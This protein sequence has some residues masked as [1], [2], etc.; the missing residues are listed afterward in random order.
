MSKK[1]INK[2]VVQLIGLVAILAIFCIISIFQSGGNAQT[3]RYTIKNIDKLIKSTNLEELPYQLPDRPDKTVIN[4]QV[5]TEIDIDR[6]YQQDQVYL[7]YD[8]QGVLKTIRI[9][10]VVPGINE[11]GRETFEPVNDVIYTYTRGEDGKLVRYSEINPMQGESYVTEVTYDGNTVKHQKYSGIDLVAEF[12]QEFDDLQKMPKDFVAYNFLQDIIQM[13]LQNKQCKLVKESGT[14]EGAVVTYKYNGNNIEI[15]EDYSGEKVDRLVE[16]Q[17]N[18]VKQFNDINN[19]DIYNQL[20][21]KYEGSQLNQITGSVVNEGEQ[22][23]YAEY[24][25]KYDTL[26]NMY[27]T[28]VVNTIEAAKQ[29]AE[30]TD[31]SEASSEASSEAP[32]EASSEAPSEASSEASSEAPEDTSTAE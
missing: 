27:V 5:V 30:D 13:G 1:Q 3:G 17:G 6:G 7:S 24:S 20:D 16:V 22:S 11:F 2:I 12:T 28:S 10:Q 19:K 4:N 32:S 31:T 18:K 29:Q 21:L 9:W 15:S 26:A 8:S 25:Y 14:S 23:V